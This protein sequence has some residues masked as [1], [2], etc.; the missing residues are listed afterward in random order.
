MPSRLPLLLA[1][2]ALAIAGCGGSDANK[3]DAAPTSQEPTSTATA[4]LGGVKNY[5]LEHT[6]LLTGFTRGFAADAQRYYDLAER[7]SF[8]S[9]TLWMRHRNSVGPLVVGMKRAWW[10]ATRTTS[11]W[12]VSSQARRRWPSTT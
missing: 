12:R 3:T 1:A 11:G 10:T 9:R 8:D 7:T 4:D 6:T 2:L 5:L